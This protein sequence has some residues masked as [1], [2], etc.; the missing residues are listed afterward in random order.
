MFKETKKIIK[1]R[2]WR[3]FSNLVNASFKMATNSK[4]AMVEYHIQFFV[5][6]AL[7]CKIL[8]SIMPIRFF[9]R[10]KEIYQTILF[11]LLHVIF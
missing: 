1:I 8:I 7:K 2:F 11:K 10:T 3:I 5:I 9:S 4:K 6:K